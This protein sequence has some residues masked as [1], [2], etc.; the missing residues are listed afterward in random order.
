MHAEGVQRGRDGIEQ[1]LTRRNL[2]RLGVGTA[3]TGALAAILSACGGGSATATT[4][5]AATKA[6]TTGAT[7]GTTAPAAT[8][9]SRRG[10][11]RPGG[12]RRDDCPRRTAASGA[13][14]AAAACPRPACRARTL[15]AATPKVA[16]NA[17]ATKLTF[18]HALG[19]TNGEVV[20]NLV[21][22]FNDSQT[23]HL[24]AGRLPGHA[25]TIW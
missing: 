18:W 5:P 12:G 2:L 9:A 15:P 20:S 6:A 25:T 14:P 19:G 24:R 3:A 1:R 13:T 16:K 10:D 4:A 11:H 8:T 17:N 7:T 23:R 22:Q 21:N